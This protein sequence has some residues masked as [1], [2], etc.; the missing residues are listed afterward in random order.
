MSYNFEENICSIC[1]KAYQSPKSLSCLHVFCGECLQSNLH[2]KT[3]TITCNNCQEVHQLTREAINELPNHLPYQA[4]TT[5]QKA[6]EQIAFH[7]ETIACHNCTYQEIDGEVGNGIAYCIQCQQFICEFDK[8]AHIRFHV[9]HEVKSFDDVTFSPLKS[10][11]PPNPVIYCSKHNNTEVTVYCPKCDIAC[12]EWCARFEHINHGTKILAE[13]EGALLENLTET[14]EKA[15]E[16]SGI[17]ENMK[18]NLHQELEQ[19]KNSRTRA[20]NELDSGFQNIQEMIEGRRKYFESQ[21]NKHFTAQEIAFEKYLETIETF[22]TK[23]ADVETYYNASSKLF[24]TN[25]FFANSNTINSR[26]NSLKELIPKRE[27][28]AQKIKFEMESNEVNELEAKIENIGKISR[29]GVPDFTKSSE[30]IVA[31]DIG[32]TKNDD[33]MLSVKK[34]NLNL[35]QSPT[36]QESKLPKIEL[37]LIPQ[38]NST[39]DHISSTLSK[40]RPTNLSVNDLRRK[41]ANIPHNNSKTPANEEDNCI[42]DPSSICEVKRCNDGDNVVTYDKQHGQVHILNKEFECIRVIQV[43]DEQVPRKRNN[44][45]SSSCSGGGSRPNSRPGSRLSGTNSPDVFPTDGT[46]RPRTCSPFSSSKKASDIQTQSLATNSKNQ[47]LVAH[48]NEPTFSAFS[49]DGKRVDTVDYQRHLDNS[50]YHAMGT[51]MVRSNSGNLSPSL[52]RSNSIKRVSSPLTRTNSGRITPK[53][54][55][56]ER[57]LITTDNLDNIYICRKKH[58]LTF[59]ANHEFIKKDKLGEKIEP[60]SFSVNPFGEAYILSS[61]GSLHRFSVQ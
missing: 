54:R 19:L 23:L 28:K 22:K 42:T 48:E 61:K 13:S 1:K 59:D 27:L 14:F 3:N 15:K 57:T 38:T 53:S 32:I 36:T 35:I 26:V 30:I 17:V 43:R 8:K 12:C 58:I 11:L 51:G 56:E 21:I 37:S 29:V 39:S 4:I 45:T 55:L 20:L 7:P 24:P 9:T 44:S 33:L 5:V 40:V 50:T 41:N 34:A 49:I 60:V 6:L 16:N 18:S 25:Y 31:S 2:S 10:L 47:I 52:S 46:I